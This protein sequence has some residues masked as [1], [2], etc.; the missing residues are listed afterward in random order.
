MRQHPNLHEPNKKILVVGD[1]VL[2]DI[3]PNIAYWLEMDDPLN[4][5]LTNHEKVKLVIIQGVEVWCG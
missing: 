4:D 3:T 2:S 5:Y 1:H